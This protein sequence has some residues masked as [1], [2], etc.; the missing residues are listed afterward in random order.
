[1]QAIAEGFR[2]PDGLV[3]AYPVTLLSATPS[4]ARL[5]S[6]MDPMLN[7]NILLNLLPLYVPPAYDP[8]APVRRTAQ[9]SR[10]PPSMQPR[11]RNRRRELTPSRSA[12][13]AVLRTRASHPD[14]AFAATNAFLSPGRAPEAALRAFP[15]TRIVVGE[16]DPLLDDSVLMYRR[17]KAA[18][19]DDVRLSIRPGL[20]HGFLNLANV[21][22]EALEAVRLVS[23]WL[24][25]WAA[26]PAAAATASA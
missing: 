12:A 20:A 16:F 21:V 23:L 3:L 10:P 26:V 14:A 4:C 5:L 1:M 19:H 7:L 17:L 2:V 24:Q 6:V 11:G 22:P 25:E 8:G 18:G 9:R 15:P 13:H